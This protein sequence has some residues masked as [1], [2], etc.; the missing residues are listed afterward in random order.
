MTMQQ[1]SGLGEQTQP[2]SPPSSGEP[3]TT[4]A[5]T[6][7]GTASKPINLFELE[8]F[9]QW[10]SQ[11]DQRLAQERAARQQ[12][13]Q[14]LATLEQ[15]QQQRELEQLDSLDAEEQV[16]VLKRRMSQ[17]N[18]A[19]EEQR[20]SQQYAQ[21]AYEMLTTAGLTW[22]DPRIQHVV[23]LGPTAQMVQQLSVALVQIA[24]QEVEA[25]KL[26][27]QVQAQRLTEAA[28]TQTQIETTRARQEAIAEAG[29]TVTSGEPPSAVTPRDEK[30]EKL[31]GFKAR[32]RTIASRNG[33]P[34]SPEVLRF[35][36]DL[37]AAGLTLA[38][39][40]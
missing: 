7:P 25:A 37:R 13:E 9:R 30:A 39:L 22:Q 1:A 8:E 21:Q 34:N 14:R 5:A 35:Q 4:P 27:A 12:T 11:S 16:K 28:K 32:F 19:A 2:I 18:R 26:A 31:A 3:Q 38:D 20:V 17:Q 33:G 15:Q 29:V 36:Q 24:K 40:R 10:Q 6:S 23:P